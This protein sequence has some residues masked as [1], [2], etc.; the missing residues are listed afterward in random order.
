MRGFI[1]RRATRP[2]AHMIKRIRR[3][4]PLAGFQDRPHFTFQLEE[5]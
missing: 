3:G 5:R 4:P 1:G 2:R